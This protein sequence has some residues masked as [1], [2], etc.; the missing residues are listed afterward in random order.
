MPPFSGVSFS[1]ALK[2]LVKIYHMVILSSTSL[3]RLDFHVA[4]VSIP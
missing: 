1:N 3:G 2:G 4:T